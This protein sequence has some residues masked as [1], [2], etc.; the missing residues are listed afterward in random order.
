[1]LAFRVGIAVAVRR[2]LRQ[3]AASAASPAA[4]G[5]AV[6]AAGGA[7]VAL[8]AANHVSTCSE[9]PER[10]KIGGVRDEYK[11]PPREVSRLDPPISGFFSKEIVVHGVPI[12]AH[13]CVTDAALLVAADRLGRMLRY[14][15]PPVLERLQRR[16]ACLHVI[17]TDQGCSDLPEH[18][19]MKGVD[20]GYT[21][22]CGVTI[23]QR[24]RGM[25]G[26]LS[27]CGEEN[28][29]DV[30]YRRIYH[31]IYIYICIFIGL[32]VYLCIYTHTHTHTHTHIYIY[33][34]IYI[35]I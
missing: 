33:I 14:L 31:Y 22:E 21:G 19:H 2:G 11:T 12:R 3:A 8:G 24:A 10:L 26:T 28:L 9:R 30:R 17:G 6:M 1:M 29:L 25:G 20:G 18:A 16:G 4:R 13:A 7:V 27:S 23:D 34:Y 15:P 35:Y 32:S 5:W